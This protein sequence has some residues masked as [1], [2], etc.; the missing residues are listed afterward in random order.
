M[1]KVIEEVSE[2]KNKHKLGLTEI[3]QVSEAKEKTQ[4]SCCERMA[5]IK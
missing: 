1:L 4:I 2:S 5:L 3:E